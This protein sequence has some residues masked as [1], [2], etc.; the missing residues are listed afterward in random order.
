M[1]VK[2]MTL[3]QVRIAGYQA[4]IRDLGPVNL[5]RFLQ[6]FETGYGDYT[7]ERRQWLDR[8]TV[9]EIAREVQ[10]HNEE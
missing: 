10:A 7:K 5:V 4:L 9:E 1:T 2:T 3:E 6:H 8:H